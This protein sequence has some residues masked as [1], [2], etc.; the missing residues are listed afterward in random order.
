MRC[1]P[2]SAAVDMF[3]FIMEFEDKD[4]YKECAEILRNQYSFTGEM[5]LRPTENDKWRLSA[6]AEKRFRS[7]TFEKLPGKRIEEG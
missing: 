4:E 3:S 2:L 7:S 5:A 6:H 1:K